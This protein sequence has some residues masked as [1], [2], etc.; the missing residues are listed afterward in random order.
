M[1][2]SR[3]AAGLAAEAP[4]PGVG[5]LVGL[6]AL[7]AVIAPLNST[8]IA[9]ALPDIRTAFNLSH[10][11]AGWL[12]SSYLIAMAVV[13]PLGGRIGDQAG[14][15]RVL[16]WGLIGCLVCSVGAMA[17]ADFTMLVAFRTAQAVF[18]AILIPNGIALL[19]TAAPPEQLGRLNGINGAVLSTAAAAGPLLGA[20]ALA[21]GSWRFIFVLNIPLV[22][23]TLI[24]LARL[25]L[26][27]IRIPSGW[28]IDWVGTL[29]FVALLCGVTFQLSTARDDGFGVRSVA[30]W[31]ATGA[32]SA[33]F[34]W[35][36]HSSTR[37]AAEWHLFRVRAFSGATSWI[38]LTN[39]SMYTTLLMIPYFIDDVQGKSTE[40]SGLLLGAMSILVALVSPLGGR[41]SDAL[42][43]RPLM[44][45]G[46]A[47][48]L[49]GAAALFA[50]LRVGTPAWLLATC[51]AVFG[52]G[53]G[54]GTGPAVSAALEAAP[55]GSAGA[56]SGTSSMM[57][58][59]GSIIGAGLLA[60]VLTST[61]GAS[62]DL[63]TFRVVTTVIVATAGLA[64]IAAIFAHRFV[65]PEREN[66]VE[67]SAE[68]FAVA[69][70]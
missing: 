65:E 24:L 30:G 34:V 66:I 32:I 68:P 36:Q 61:S 21:L 39:L 26:S 8:M 28:R 48:A 29:L 16:G 60:G 13:Q 47:V 12:I 31:A 56:A 43:R 35:R 11:A 67:P 50:A 57:R 10:A 40:L 70:Q 54:L 52:V 22:I 64:C 59:T 53:L 44:L 18:A 3:A 41:L 45:A 38:L 63:T 17:A 6:A 33:L 42:G 25:E 7:G 1:K 19:R 62:G 69:R 14:R 2:T 51:L 4:G 37:P 46:A 55:L 23:V 27:E 9:V 15:K 58:Y 20:G 49:V 5:L